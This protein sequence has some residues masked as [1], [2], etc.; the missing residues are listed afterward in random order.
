MGVVASELLDIV[1]WEVDDQQ[2]TVA[3]EQAGHLGYRAVGVIEEVE[4]LMGDDEIELAGSERGAEDVSLS[5]LDVV[6]PGAVEVGAGDT[7]HRVVRIESDHPCRRRCQELHHSSGAGADVENPTES[8]AALGE[9]LDDH[10]ED[11]FVGGG[12]GPLAIPVVGMGC[13]VV[14]SQVGA[15]FAYLVETSAIVSESRISRIS[16]VENRPAGGGQTTPIGSETEEDEAALA[17]A[18]DE[19]GVVQLTEMAGDPRLGLPEDLAQ[20]AHRTLAVAQQGDDPST[21]RFG[22]RP[23]RLDEGIEAD[24]AG[25]ARSTFVL[26][27]RIVRRTGLDPGH[28][29]AGQHSHYDMHTLTYRDGS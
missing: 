20:V 10:R 11:Q 6:D 25:T 27:P 4:D 18:A 21:R 29:H 8:V 19:S 14:V 16:G 2:T 17:V 1:W 23:Q 22:E 15:A 28:S 26:G 7:E 9:H 13:E 5:E 12:M 24:C 3:V